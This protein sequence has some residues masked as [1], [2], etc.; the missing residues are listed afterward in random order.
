MPNWIRNEAVRPFGI[1]AMLG[2]G[3]GGVGEHIPSAVR[4]MNVPVWGL[5]YKF[6]KGKIKENKIK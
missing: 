3:A 4:V 6:T 1:R 5:R 2:A